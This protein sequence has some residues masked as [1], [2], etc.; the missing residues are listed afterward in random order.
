MKRHKS[1][2]PLSQQH[3]DVLILAQLIKRNAP[4]YKGLPTEIEEKRKYTL[5]KFKEYLVPHFEAEE[6]IL[7]PF[8]IGRDKDVDLLCE[9]IITEHQK[10]A[11]L[12]E[13]IRIKKSLEDNMNELGELLSSHIR[14]EERKLFQKIQQF[15]SAEQI[16]KL[17]K[18]L[19]YL[20]KFKSC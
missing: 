5:E 2:I 16:D 20:N 19:S 13:E 12:V 9:E 3:H 15:L 18:E 14:K 4:H 17:G 1:L 7:I 6:L 8:I 11:S 10:I